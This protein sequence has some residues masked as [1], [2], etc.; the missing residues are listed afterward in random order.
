MGRNTTPASG[1][2]GRPQRPG[3]PTCLLGTGSPAAYWWCSKTKGIFYLSEYT[4]IPWKIESMGFFLRYI[5]ND[6]FNGMRNERVMYYI[7]TLKCL[8]MTSASW[9]S[10]RVRIVLLFI[11]LRNRLKSSSRNWT[12]WKNCKR[13]IS[14]LVYDSV[15][16]LVIYKLNCEGFVYFYL[17]VL[18]SIGHVSLQT[19]GNL[20]Q[21]V[22]TPLQRICTVLSI[23]YK[24][25]LNQ[26]SR[27]HKRH[28]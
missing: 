16:G 28:L 2:W 10:T 25:R 13:I 27:R 20:G 4:G 22:P 24:A 1:G 23:R 14:L 7:F 9:V 18:P 12:S 6:I 19:L 15:N 21:P 8:H 26:L 5:F 3:F 17:V 11:N